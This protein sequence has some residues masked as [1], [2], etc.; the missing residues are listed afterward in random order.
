MTSIVKLPSRKPARAGSDTA[1]AT[2][3][4]TGEEAAG[5]TGAAKGAPDTS[6]RPLAAD[7]D[8]PIDRIR[9]ALRT[10]DAPNADTRSR[11]YLGLAGREF[12]LQHSDPPD[13]D[14]GDFQRGATTFF[15]LGEDA[16]VQDADVN[17]PRRPQ[18]THGDLED[19]PAYLRLEPD[20]D[21]P[22]WLLEDATVTVN[23][24]RPSQTVYTNPRL[25]GTDDDH[26]IW[27]GTR[28]GRVLH[29]KHG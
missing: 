9:V 8:E 27:L 23:P 11:L 13:G 21:E 15:N 18:L 5:S 14:A 29:L 3:T 19:F 28:Q 22:D 20:G 7:R 16:D 6:G 12:R 2:A 17:D 24:D 4:S 10:V 26:R 1:A 25:Y